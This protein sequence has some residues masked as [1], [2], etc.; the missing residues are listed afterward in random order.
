[1]M[2]LHTRQQMMFSAV[3][4]CSENDMNVIPQDE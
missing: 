1:M 4:W 2:M 3:E